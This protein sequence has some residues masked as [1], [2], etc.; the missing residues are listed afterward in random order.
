M[1]HELLNIILMT[2]QASHLNS[3]VLIKYLLSVIFV[4]LSTSSGD[5]TPLFNNSSSVTPGKKK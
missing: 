3:K 1:S 4:N 5:I 2:R